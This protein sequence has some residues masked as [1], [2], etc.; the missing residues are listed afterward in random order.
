MRPSARS[1]AEN[2]PRLVIVELRVRTDYIIGQCVVNS[3]RTE[4]RYVL[5]VA[6]GNLGR[7]AAVDDLAV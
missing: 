5:L 6:Q 4:A 7:A 1:S 2:A 3:T